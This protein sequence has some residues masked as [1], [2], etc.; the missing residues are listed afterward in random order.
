MAAAANLL[1]ATVG[2][3]LLCCIVISIVGRG[4]SHVYASAALYLGGAALLIA[5][6]CG[7]SMVTM[8]LLRSFPADCASAPDLLF[9]CRSFNLPH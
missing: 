5:A 3:W 8:I 4:V 2:F 9:G 6:I 1:I 7:W